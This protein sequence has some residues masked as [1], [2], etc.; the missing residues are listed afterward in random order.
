MSATAVHTPAPQDLTDRQ[1]QVYTLIA[2]Y[3]EATGEPPSVSFL[4]RKMSV[5]RTTI[6][7]HLEAICRKGWLSSPRPWLQRRG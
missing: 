7:F 2:R 3:V 4:A 6:Q 5:H 1:R